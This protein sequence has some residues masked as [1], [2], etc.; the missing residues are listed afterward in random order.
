MPTI[1]FIEAVLS[2][3][4]SRERELS[5]RQ[6]GASAAQTA[7]RVGAP[8]SIVFDFHSSW[9]SDHGF[10]SD[11][12]FVHDRLLRRTRESICIEGR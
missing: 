6:V 7:R 3:P 2:A 1:P 9:Q 11:S 12:R 8:D 4:A 10:W 5:L